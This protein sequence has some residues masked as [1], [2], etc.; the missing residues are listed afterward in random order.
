MVKMGVAKATDKAKPMNIPKLICGICPKHIKSWSK[1]LKMI[2]M[3][4]Q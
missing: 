1:S 3:V 2:L 4:M